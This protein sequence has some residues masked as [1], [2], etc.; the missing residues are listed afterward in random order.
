MI[1]FMKRPRAVFSP[2]DGLLRNEHFQ[3]CYVTNDID[4]ACDIF[5]DRFGIR[6]FKKLEGRLATGGDVRVEL[7]WAGGTMYELVTASGPGSEFY[8]ERLPTTGTFAMHHHH[9]GFLVHDEAG[10]NALEAEIARGCWRIRAANNSIGFLRHCY[11][12]VPEIGHF[13]EY[14][15]PEARGVE[16]FESVPSN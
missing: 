15:L 9:F 4:R 10:W 2:G 16:F 8:T 7:A 12:E 3:I 13:L 14:I 6:G 11:I 5:R 1:E